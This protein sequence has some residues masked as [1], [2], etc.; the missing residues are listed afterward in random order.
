MLF[1]STRRRP[2]TSFLP[3]NGDGCVCAA[4]SRRMTAR[5]GRRSHRH[6]QRTNCH[7]QPRAAA[8]AGY[9]NEAEVKAEKRVQARLVATWETS[10]NSLE[11]RRFNT[12]DT[13]RPPS[14]SIRL[15]TR[16]WCARLQYCVES[17]LI[18]NFGDPVVSPTVY[19]YAFVSSPVSCPREQTRLRLLRGH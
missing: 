5:A 13:S 16:L 7:V 18:Y 1:L 15:V 17:P 3:M 11:V 10:P 4:S 6:K 9:T 14:R 12:I 8:Q 2:Q 19:V